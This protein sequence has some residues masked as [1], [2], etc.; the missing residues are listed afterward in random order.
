MM[1]LILILCLG[2]KV[3]V[4]DQRVSVCRDHA[5]GICQRQQC[6]YY[7]IPVAIPPAN[8]M[9]T[10]IVSPR[11]TTSSS[12]S[13]SSQPSSNAII[14]D[15]S[16]ADLDVN[17]LYP[18]V[19]GTLTPTNHHNNNT[20]NNYNNHSN[21]FTTGCLTSITPTTI[22]ST[23]T[24]NTTTT[25]HTVSTTP[26][27]FSVAYQQKSAGIPITSSDDGL[28]ID[29]HHSTNQ[30]I[31]SNSCPTTSNLSASVSSTLSS[32]SSID[33]AQL[34]LWHMLSHNL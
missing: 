14:V 28:R 4:I 29:R 12:T 23:T 25:H 31:S 1:L 2:D 11:S 8:V 20:N 3:E 18:I 13:A 17:N 7:H 32:A 16:G 15:S 19:A 22:T 26:P 21:V 5:N 24:S 6:K 34:S 27:N 9:A 30:L 33:V 10:A